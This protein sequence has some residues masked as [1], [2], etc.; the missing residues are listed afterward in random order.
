MTTKSTL[1]TALA[2]TTGKQRRQLYQ[3]ALAI[4]DEAPPAMTAD[5][6]LCHDGGDDDPC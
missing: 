5:P 3:L 4:R 1:V 2:L 6:A